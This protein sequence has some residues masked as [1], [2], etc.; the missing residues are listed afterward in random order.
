M[1][2]QALLVFVLV[3]IGSVWGSAGAWRDFRPS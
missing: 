2:R 3:A 1:Q